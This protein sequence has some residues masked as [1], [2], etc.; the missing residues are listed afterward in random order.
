M[1]QNID[2]LGL[3]NEEYERER[4]REKKTQPLLA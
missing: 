4:G 2:Q 3:K 1:G